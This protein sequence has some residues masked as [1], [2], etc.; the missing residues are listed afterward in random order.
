[1]KKLV[2]AVAAL[3]GPFSAHAQTYP[4]RPIIVVGGVGTESV[5]RTIAEHMKT[6]L[7]QPIVFENTTG[8]VWEAVPT[9]PTTTIG[10]DG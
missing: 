10:R 5:G 6:S 8:A 3:V 7:G 9:P 1:M 2:F 4:S